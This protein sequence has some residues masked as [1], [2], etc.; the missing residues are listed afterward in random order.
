MVAGIG[1]SL[2][3]TAVAI[4]GIIAAVG[5]VL[6]SGHRELFLAL[7]WVAVFAEVLWLRT[8][9]LFSHLALYMLA[10]ERRINR[11]V[12]GDA[13]AWQSKVT[14]GAAPVPAGVPGGRE[15]HP[16]A[17]VYYDRLFYFGI[18]CVFSFALAQSALWVHSA[19]P[20][21]QPLRVMAS[22]ADGLVTSGVAAVILYVS[23]KVS[24]SFYRD[25]WTRLQR[26]WK[27]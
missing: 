25:E 24:T 14:V 18:F 8:R 2:S 10:L 16:P 11:A 23:S 5:V 13:L 4:G 12:G 3:I 17:A 6:Q 19:C 21:S 15:D 27:L 26:W 1:A 9:F 7:P 20:G 22:V